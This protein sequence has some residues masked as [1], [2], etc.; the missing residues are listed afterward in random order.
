MLVGVGLVLIRAAVVQLARPPPHL[1]Q[2]HLGPLDR[3]AEIVHTCVEVTSSSNF[4]TG[5]ALDTCIR[6]SPP[7]TRVIRLHYPALCMWGRGGGNDL[8]K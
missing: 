5:G 6:L 4:L 1:L 3:G 2:G 7:C 8:V